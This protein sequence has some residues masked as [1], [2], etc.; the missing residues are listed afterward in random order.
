MLADGEIVGTW[1]QRKKRLTLEVDVSPWRSVT[2]EERDGL[3]ADAAAV[4]Q[5]RGLTA[6]VSVG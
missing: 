6:K 1:R 4:A 2:T 3:E 5:T